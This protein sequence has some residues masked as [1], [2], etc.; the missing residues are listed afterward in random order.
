MA[1]SVRLLVIIFTTLLNIEC[2][3]NRREIFIHFDLKGAPPRPNYFKQLLTLVSELGAD[4]ALIEWEDMFPYTGTLSSIK[5]GNAYSIGETMDILQHADSL[6]L[7]VIPLV[8]T[9]GH[10]EWILKTKEFAGLRE[11]ASFPMTVCIGNPQTLTLMLDAIHQVMAMHSNTRV[12]YIH[13]GADEAFQ[14][15]ECDADQKL[16]PLKYANS[17]KRLTLDYIRAIATNITQAFKK[18]KV[19]M[20]FERSKIHRPQFDQG[21]RTE[22]TSN[23]SSVEV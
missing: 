7:S 6:D 21:V 8:Q 22:S 23:P 17:T 15:G 18:T 14:I 9:V 3:R 13:I 20:W 12:P 19:L 16:L 1:N 10:L 2:Q 5:N 11:N 4:G